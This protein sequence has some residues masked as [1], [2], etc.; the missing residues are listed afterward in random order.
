MP[1]K[2]LK[3]KAQ[4]WKRVEFTHPQ[5]QTHAIGL[6]ARKLLRDKIP[7][8]SIS[9]NAKIDVKKGGLRECRTEESG[10]NLAALG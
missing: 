3:R 2:V 6:K 8:T 4:K 5:Y 9:K 7:S 10:G 1:N